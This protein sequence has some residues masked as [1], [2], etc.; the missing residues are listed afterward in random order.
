MLS[1]AERGWRASLEDQGFS[2]RLVNEAL[3]IELRN[4]AYDGFLLSNAPPARMSQTTHLAGRSMDLGLP[5]PFYEQSAASMFRQQQHIPTYSTSDSRGDFWQQQ[6]QQ[7]LGISPAPPVA[8]RQQE[9]LPSLGF[10]PSPW[11]PFPATREEEENDRRR[12]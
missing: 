9:S 7:P 12:F 2:R 3:Q 1:E 5:P 8:P 10:R 11:F 6:Q 4:R